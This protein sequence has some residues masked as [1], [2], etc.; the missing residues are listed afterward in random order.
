MLLTR[1]HGEGLEAFRRAAFN[2]LARNRDDHAKNFA[3]ILDVDAG[4]W[5]LCP[6]YDLSFSQ[7]PGGEHAMAVMG[8]GRAP[9][10]EQLLRLAQAREVDRAEATRILD[11]V[12]A[13]VS[14]WPAFAEAA[15]LAAKPAKAIGRVLSSPAQ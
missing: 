2:V 6:A 11:Q 13:A 4:T 1:S 8:E 7:G 12:R 15:G 3:F 10:L 9:G 14:Q 5:G